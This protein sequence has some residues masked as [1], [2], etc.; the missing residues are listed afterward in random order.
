MGQKYCI[1]QIVALIRYGILCLNVTLINN[2]T[3][4]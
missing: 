2:V 1:D 4:I 3:Q